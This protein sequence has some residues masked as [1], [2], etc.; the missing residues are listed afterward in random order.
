VY[1]AE[2][3]PTPA[4][5]F[6]IPEEL[7]SRAQWVNW[8]LEERNGKP[9]KVPY[10]PHTA[11][12]ASSTDSATWSTFAAVISAFEKVS[13]AGIGFCFSSGDPYTGIDLDH[14][15]DPKTGEIAAW[16]QIWVEWL[17]GYTEVSPSGEGLHVIVKGKSPHN[18]KKTV[19]GKTVE[20]YSTERFF[21]FTGAQP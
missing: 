6:R 12:R 5:F 14:C 8:R 7:R 17:N 9:T 20:I 13:Y 19:D 18:G 10:N 4:S 15:R 21:T 16:A 2:H 3:E 11:E 1:Q